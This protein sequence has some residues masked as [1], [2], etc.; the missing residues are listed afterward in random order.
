MKVSLVIPM[1]NEQKLIAATVDELKNAFPDDYELIFSNDGSADGCEKVVAADPDPRVKLVDNKVNR[2]KGAAIRDGIAAST[3]DIVVYTDC[4]LAYGT[5]QIKAI[6]AAHVASGADVTAGSRKKHPD[7][8]A[9]YS[10]LRRLISHVYLWV[11]TVTSGCPVSD[12]QTGLKCFNG[13]AARDV[14]SR[15]E[16]NRFAFDL[17]ALTVASKLGYT[18]TDFPVCIERSDKE[19][20]RTSSIHFFR[21][22]LRMLRDVFAMKRRLKKQLTK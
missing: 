22:S 11:I 1:Y 15:C 5:E 13:N 6:I 19:L 3:G 20:G 2:G 8:Y 10:A 16:I 18:V 12:S 21:D 7:G 4:D 14:F 9:G 17:E